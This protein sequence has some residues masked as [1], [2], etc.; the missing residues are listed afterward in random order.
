[1]VAD[2]TGKA[3]MKAAPL[4]L[5]ISSLPCAWAILFAFLPYDIDDL[6]IE[7]TFKGELA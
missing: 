6:L 7:E 5:P 3:S 1:M 2:E 4:C